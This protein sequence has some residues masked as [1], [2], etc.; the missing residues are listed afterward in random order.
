MTTTR[1]RRSASRAASS[2]CER[3]LLPPL[4]RATDR[5]HTRTYTHTHARASARSFLR[6]LSFARAL[7]PRATQAAGVGLIPKQKKLNIPVCPCHD[8]ADYKPALPPLA[9]VSYIRIMKDGLPA[10]DST[11]LAIEFTLTKADE[12]F[13]DAL[14]KKLGAADASKVAP[15]VA[16]FVTADNV[17][18]VLASSARRR[19]AGADLARSGRGALRAR[20]RAARAAATGRRA[21][22]AVAVTTLRPSLLPPPPPRRARARFGALSGTS[23]ARRRGGLAARAGTRELLAAIHAHGRAPRQVGGKPLIRRF[24]CRRR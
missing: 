9:S 13:A 23:A 17:E 16:Q 2:R 5:A 24:W 11:S 15:S 12:A 4:A 6:A 10:D 22:P 20:P 1:A 8:V 3:A 14:A 7:S 18:L 21:P 19:R